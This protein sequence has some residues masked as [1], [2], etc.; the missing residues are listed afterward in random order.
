[1]NYINIQCKV[2][3]TPLQSSC[4][5]LALEQHLE[6][7]LGLSPKSHS[8]TNWKNIFTI[9]FVH[10]RLVYSILCNISRMK[11]RCSAAWDDFSSC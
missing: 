10:H 4:S 2:K 5:D 1:M 7:R 8:R 3:R 11:D 9:L 6:G